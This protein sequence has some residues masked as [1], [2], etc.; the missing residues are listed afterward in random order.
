MTSAAAV[1]VL[2]LAPPRA[3]AF[4]AFARKYGTSCSACHVGWPIFNQEGQNFRDNGYQIEPREGRPGHALARLPAHRDPHHA[5]LP[6]HAD[7]E[8]ARRRGARGDDAHRRRARSRRASTSSPAAS[9]RRTSRS[10]SWSRAS[11]RTAPRR[12]SRPGRGSTTSR[13]SRWLEPAHREV[14]AGPAGVVAPE[15]DAHLRLR[16]LQR[17]PRGQPGR[18]R[19]RGEPGRRRAGRPRRP[20]HHPLLAQRH[21]RERGRGA[22][23]ERL[24]GADGVR[25]RAARLRA[26]G[27]PLALGTGRRARWRR[28]VAHRASTRS[29][30]TQASRSRSPAPDAITR[31]STG[32][33]AIS[34]GWWATR[35]P[36]SSSRSPTCTGGRRPASPATGA[37]RTPSTA[38]SPRST[39]CPSPSRATTRPRGCSS[40]R[41]DLVRFGHGVGDVDGGTIGVRRYI[42][43]GPRASA[44][45][46]IE[47]HVDRAKGVSL[48]PAE[49]PLDVTTQSALAGIDFD[50]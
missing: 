8:P 45:I 37:A 46:H 49:T 34:P 42:A 35:R 41:Y 23:L 30:T 17:P 13:H 11:A 22:L 40:R 36:R 43:L 26:A 6:V 39:G 29:R 3:Q 27:G 38:G 12:S 32:P 16:G 48:V 47:A 10:S 31:G 33:A 44:A 14:R 28:L 18:L 19:L 15:R 1:L 25:P 9:S 2:A 24:V 7:D 5:R 20:Q 50:F 21:L 4:P